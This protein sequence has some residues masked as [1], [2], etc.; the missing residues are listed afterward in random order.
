MGMV[1]ELVVVVVVTETMEELVMME[2]E[3]ES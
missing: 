1:V 2:R 3:R